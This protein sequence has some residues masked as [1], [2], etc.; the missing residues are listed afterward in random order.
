MFRRRRALWVGLIVLMLA[1]GGRT[2]A[3]GDTGGSGAGTA[4]KANYAYS[5]AASLLVGTFDLEGT[6]LANV[7]SGMSG[8]QVDKRG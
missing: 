4:L 7:G 8:I 3:V 2:S 6:G 5:D 1:D